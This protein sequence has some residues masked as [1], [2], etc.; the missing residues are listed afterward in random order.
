VR[1]FDKADFLEKYL[2]VIFGELPTATQLEQFENDIRN[3]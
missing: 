3:L 2:L 1:T